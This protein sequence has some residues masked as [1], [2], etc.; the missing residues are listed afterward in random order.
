MLFFFH[1]FKYMIKKSKK[2]GGGGGEEFI[3][4]HPLTIVSS[5]EKIYIRRE[6]L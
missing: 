3:K 5:Q 6:L 4:L 1:C 2:E